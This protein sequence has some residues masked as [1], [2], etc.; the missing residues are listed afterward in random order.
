MAGT[1]RGWILRSEQAYCLQLCEKETLDYGIAY[2]SEKFRD[3]HDA[4]QFREVL[5]EDESQT[6][7]AIE[8]AEAWFSA[9]GLTCHRWAPA[10]Y[11]DVARLGTKLKSRGF[12]ER[13]ITALALTKWVDIKAPSDV[14]VLPARAMR[15]AFRET[16]SHHDLM[17]LNLDNNLVQ[18]VY[19]E[20]LNDAPLEMMVALVDRKPAG[21]CGL[22][23]VGDI[24]RVMDLTVLPEFESRGVAGALLANILTMA[25]RL[26]IRNVCMAVASSEQAKI[27]LLHESGFVT[28]GQLIEFERT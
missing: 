12:R 14:R 10:E 2:H 22:Y 5:I 23:Q 4:N 20:R 11:Q 7:A 15:T 9:R 28:D 1:T 16:L 19:E 24:A 18:Q 26:A 6:D 3:H 25:K 8:Q 21:R 27:N 13:P 17:H